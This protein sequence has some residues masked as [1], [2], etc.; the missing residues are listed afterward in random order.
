MGAEDGMAAAKGKRAGAA[1]TRRPKAA[2]ASRSPDAPAPADAA[3]TQAAPAEAARRG[4]RGFAHASAASAATLRK[5][6][7]KRGFAETRVLTDWDAIAGPALAPLC[8]PL[9][10]SFGSGGFGAT[11]VVL[12]EGALAPEVEM[13]APR[14]VERINAH[15]GYRAVARIRITQTAP[16]LS[17]APSTGF[18]EPAP[19]FAR[20]PPSRGSDPGGT[21][22][23]HGGLGSAAPEGHQGPRRWSAPVAAALEGVADPGLRAALER[24]GRG[25]MGRGGTND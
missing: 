14:L 13:Q 8:R 5:A 4:G 18:A 19:G 24:L 3:P 25:V 9:K 21:A 11:L 7:G 1:A 2:T 12:A 20:P 10:V 17:A 6:A 22:A 16:G 15:Y 23:A